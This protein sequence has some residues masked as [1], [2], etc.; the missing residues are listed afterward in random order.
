MAE[1]KAKRLFSEDHRLPHPSEQAYEVLHDGLGPWT[2]GDVVQV[3]LEIHAVAGGA[4]SDHNFRIARLLQL[5]AI[6]PTDKPLFK[7]PRG[8]LLKRRSG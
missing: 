5:H 4:H 8:I 3:H 1:L 2:K 7:A 6:R